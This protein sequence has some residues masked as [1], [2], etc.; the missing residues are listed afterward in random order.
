MLVGLKAFL[1]IGFVDCVKLVLLHFLKDFGVD[2]L[3]FIADS[4]TSPDGL[5]SNIFLPKP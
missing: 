2:W 3:V 4:Y 1:Y 5:S